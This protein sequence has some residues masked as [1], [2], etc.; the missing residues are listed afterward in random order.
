[1]ANTL[2]FKRGLASGIPTALAGEPLFTTDTFD[3]YIGNG[4]GNTR[5][6]KY[7]ASGTT[8]QVIRGDGSLYNFP[9]DI[10]SPSNGQVLKYNGTSWV[11]DSDSGITGSLTT[12]YLPKATG[13][14][15]LG[16]SLVYDNGT[17]VG[18]GT[19]SPNYKLDLVSSTDASLFQ[20]TSTASANN[21]AL[22]MGIDGNNAFIN[23]T[24]GS[25]GTL[26]LRTY[27]STRATLDTN[28]N[29]GLAL[30]PSAWASD[31]K[32]IQVSS[33]AAFGGDSSDK[34][35]AVSNNY[36]NDGSAKY[37]GTGQASLYSQYQGN[38]RFFVAGSG[39]ANGAI[40]FTQ[41]MTLTALNNLLIGS[42]S[43]SGEKL[44]VTGTAKIT[45][46]AT[47]GSTISTNGGYFA[48]RSSAASALGYF[49]QTKDWIGGGSTDANPALATESSYGLNFYT[50][51]STTLK[52]R[53]DTSG[54]LGLG[55]T[56]SAWT[57]GGKNIEVGS[58]G[59]IIQGQASQIAVIQNATFNLGWKYSANGFASFI[60]QTNGQHQWFTAP[61]GTA[62]A[63]ITFTQAM[64]LDASGNLLLNT[65]STSVGNANA[66]VAYGGADSGILYLYRT[67]GT[68]Q[69]RFYV[70][71]NRLGY[72]NTASSTVRLGT[73]NYPLA[74]DT[75]DTERMRIT[76]GGNTILAYSGSDSGER[77]QVNGTAKITG[78]STL[79]TSSAGSLT[80]KIRNEVTS[81]SANTGYGLAIES[82]A[83]GA[84]SYA[85]TIRNLAETTTYFHVSTATG[86]VGNVGIG[87]IAPQAKLVVLNSS[88]TA[89]PSLGSHGGHFQLQNGTFGLLSGVTTGGNA[90]MQVQRTDGT[91]TAY[92]LILQPTAGSVFIGSASSSS[93]PLYLNNVS[94]NNTNLA[95][96][97][98]STDKWYIRNITS[99]DAFSFYSVVGSLEAMR[100]NT[101]GAAIFSS[102]IE[103][104]TAIAIGTTPDTN[105]PFK[106]LKNINATVGIKFEN[107]NTS[108]SAFSA[109]QLG[110]DV[111]GGT[112]F[113]NLVYSSS[114]VSASGVYQ[115]DGTSLIN[116]GNGGLNFL[117][118]PIRMY[119]G[120]SN[121]V[122][123]WDL[124]NDGYITH[125]SAT[126][127]TTSAT[128]SYRQYSADVTAGNAAP[129]FRTEN[130]AVIKLY[131]ETTA[132]GNSIISLGGGNSVL[133]D[134]T[135][136]GYTLRQ[137]V[138][139]LRNQGILA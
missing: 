74:F 7:I 127:P 139:A 76:S 92:N 124:V 112:K 104:A 5:F 85:L 136:D 64:T 22:R 41:A 81:A 16:N 101:S 2:R 114:G 58:A 122:L 75:N 89:I 111:S 23:A 106:I 8:V 13:A 99:T 133:D 53:L 96:Q 51:G 59:N 71:G 100:L 49:L 86:I 121:G 63:A 3:L 35:T 90:W 109:V 56:P 138:K 25:S 31:W 105:N 84:T 65:A 32:A 55:T 91:A 82:E 78:A 98:N 38:H 26:Q 117:G 60:L 113:T 14:T 48:L 45:G 87:L 73:A 46:A 33:F 21:T 18:I 19:T 129:H 93:I 132:V 52:M 77:L 40:T 128:D 94:G 47:F 107:T 69:M 57:A 10:V 102:S 24:G 110:T 6:Q 134:T 125:Y 4:T 95:F 12:N 62:G 131:Q 20:I 88:G 83:S 44:Q 115:P 29:L 36:Y 28:G 137:I 130:G 123:R 1:M 61:S 80:A 39:S 9:L 135:F 66:L 118:N 72:I 120:G 30:T 42:T 50:N 68:D 103:A 108:S 27:G 79:T 70:G 17:N 34:T 97:Q 54:N 15:T 37:I 116:N 126:A 11:N 67:T 43:D 119:T